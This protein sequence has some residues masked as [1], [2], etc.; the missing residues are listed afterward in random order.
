MLSCQREHAPA[1][2]QR[3]RE[4]E[5]QRGGETEST[6]AASGDRWIVQLHMQPG[7]VSSDTPV[8]RVSSYTGSQTGKRRTA[9]SHTGRHKNTARLSCAQPCSFSATFSMQSA[10]MQHVKRSTHPH[11]FNYLHT[12]LALLALSEIC[13]L[14]NFV[15]QSWPLGSGFLAM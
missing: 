2:K 8:A 5:R 13:E 1:E 11:R 9:Y 14:G 10:P 15:L 6:F 7:A 4:T 12:L 3:G